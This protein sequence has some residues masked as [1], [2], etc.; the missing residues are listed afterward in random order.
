M[1]LDKPA[2]PQ[3]L[4]LRNNATYGWPGGVG[5]MRSVVV[6]SAICAH[7][8][9]CPT[10]DGSFISFRKTRARRG[11]QDH[12]IHCCAEHSQYAVA[13]WCSVD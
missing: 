3:V 13:T 7:K 11:V 9:V 2:P 6:Y 8:L 1:N 12:L 10:R 5:V 4:S